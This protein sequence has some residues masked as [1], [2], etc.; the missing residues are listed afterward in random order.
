MGWAGHVAHMGRGQVHA[1][2]WWGNLRERDY[3]EE[4]RYGWEDNS[5]MD[6]RNW[7]WGVWTGLICLRIG[8]GGRHL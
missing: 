6:L 7:D 5:N 1:G 3:L 4:T 2:F 8:T